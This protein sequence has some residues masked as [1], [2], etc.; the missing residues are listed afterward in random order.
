[1]SSAARW[2]AALVMAVLAGC[3]PSGPT[4]YPVSGTVAFDGKPVPEGDILFAPAE[5][6]AVPD[7]GNIQDG[8][9]SFRAKPGRK[10]VEIEANRESGPVDPTMGMAPRQSYIPDRYNTQ[11]TLT[12]EVKPDGENRF[13]FDLQ[14]DAASSGSGK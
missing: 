9:F 14:S 2:V 5:G 4:T 3:G 11:T 10:R 8:A 6:S 1:M 13:S 12:A 7:S